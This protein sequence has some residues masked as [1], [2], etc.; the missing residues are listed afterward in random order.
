MLIE[1]AIQYVLRIEKPCAH[2][3]YK[4][5]D[6]FASVRQNYY[7]VKLF[8]RRAGVVTLFL[9]RTILNLQHYLPTTST[10][11]VKKKHEPDIFGQTFS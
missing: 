8:R 11:L 4:F 1:L 9:P 7:V 2:F 10:Y 5:I 3:V 6:L